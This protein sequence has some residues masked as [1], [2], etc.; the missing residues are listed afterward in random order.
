MA[1]EHL[2]NGPNQTNLEN[3]D[4]TEIAGNSG[5]MAVSNLQ[6][7]RAGLFFKISSCNFVHI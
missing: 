4:D 3:Q 7:P 1:L 2:L 6:N 5:K